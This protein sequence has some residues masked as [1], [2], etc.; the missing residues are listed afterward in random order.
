M[1]VAACT[2]AQP[3]DG[4]PKDERGRTLL[5]I[6]YSPE[7]AQLFDKLAAEFDRQSRGY[8]VRATKLE[9]ADML[10]GAVEGKFTAISPDSAIWLE[11]LDQAWLAAD[12][13]RWPIVGSLSR[14]AISPVVIAM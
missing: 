11:S 13:S 8:S 3:P 4:S 12:S 10:A 5:M 14:Y 6:A 9:M 2:Q 7:K 1:L